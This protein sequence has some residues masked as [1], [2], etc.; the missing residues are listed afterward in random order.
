MCYGIWE[1][2]GFCDY[3]ICVRNDVLGEKY[4]EKENVEDEDD[5]VGDG[6]WMC[7]YVC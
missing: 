7:V 3:I 1:S 2:Y 4:I 5:G 6:C